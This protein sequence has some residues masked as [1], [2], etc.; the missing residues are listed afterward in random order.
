L[1]GC[2][3]GS[4]SGAASGGAPKPIWLDVTS[5]GAVGDGVA[6][7]TGAIRAAIDSLA[8]SG[9]TVHFPAGIYLVRPAE[10]VVGRSGVRLEGAPG[11]T[12]RCKA[13]AWQSANLLQVEGTPE[14]HVAD[15]AITGLDF[16]GNQESQDLR[17][18]SPAFLLH[19]QNADRVVISKNTFRQAPGDAIGIFPRTTVCHQI[20]IHQNRIDTC[21]RN[22]ITVAG[23]DGIDIISNSVLAFNTVG[24]D[25]E[26]GG[27]E[28]CRF[29]VVQGN[30]IRP[31]TEVLNPRNP[32]RPYGIA[33]KSGAV[34]GDAHSNVRVMG[35][36]L[37]GYAD[38]AARY[39]VVGIYLQ[40]FTESTIAFNQ[41]YDT[42]QGIRA[43]APDGPIASGP[44]GEITGNHVRGSTGTGI[45]VH[46]NMT[47][48]GNT[49]E[50]GQEAG[51]LLES[52]NNVCIGNICRRNGRG[53]SSTQRWGIRVS[54]GP[55]LVQGNTCVDD[56]KVGTQEYGIYLEDGVD[57]ATVEF[58]RLDG[59]LLGGIRL[60]SQGQND[61]RLNSGHKAQ[62]SGTGRIEPGRVSTTVLHG[63]DAIPDPEEISVTAI[64]T[65][66]NQA[67]G[68]L[69]VSEITAH[70][71][72]V[73]VER[74]PG[75]S[76]L[77]FAWE[78]SPR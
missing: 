5:A 49:V 74:E 22:G 8:A 44:G 42:P 62:S 19:L 61:I 47:V 40:N 34:A 31:S 9:G 39:P 33:L 17:R 78:V 50:E 58:N 67:P 35:N 63:L 15:I 20:T 30:V 66:P 23:G 25:L 29:I 3:K 65:E 60:P 68:A 70:S 11:S 57:G 4:G 71:F 46:S 69:S 13:G 12:I 24:I 37:Q 51:I 38:G 36:N 55:N 45:S 72:T 75:E 18:T 43:S 6:D 73:S 14:S 53:D 16:D 28:P 41:V 59:N 7:D 48:S 64:T 2:A 52:V 21:L 77:D 32:N 56:Q 26:P 1:E 76:G 10:I 27:A 54:S